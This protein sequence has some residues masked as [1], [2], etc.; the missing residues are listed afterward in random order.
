[1]TK[2][3]IFGLMFSC[4]AGMI[5]SGC[6]S[7]DGQ[8]IRKEHADSY[9]Q[10]L[11]LTTEVVL[12]AKEQFS[13]KDCIRIAIENNLDIR[14]AEVQQRVARLDRKVSF[15]QFLPQVNLNYNYTRWDPQPEMV[16]GF[17]SLPMHGERIREI[18]WEIQMSVFNPSTWFMYAMHTRGEEIAELAADYTCQMIVLQVTTYYY[19]CL[20]LQEI[21]MVLDSRINAAEA[22]AEQ[23]LD[24]QAEGLVFAWQSDQA[25]VNVQTQHLQRK[26]L[27]QLLEETQGQLLIAMGLSPLLKEEQAGTVNRGTITYSHGT[28]STG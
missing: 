14:I 20:G 24:Y 13:L 28:F 16:T 27:Q 5:L 18:T 3:K 15:S 22:L 23:L 9:R 6:S 25:R 17:G 4:I 1:M 10:K 8:K 19:Y 11:D 2:R 21:E 26:R 7:F 12:S